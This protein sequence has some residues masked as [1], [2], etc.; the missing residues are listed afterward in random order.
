MSLGGLRTGDPKQVGEWTLVGRLGAGGMGVVYLAQGADGR[1]VALKRLREDLASDPEFRE[2]FRREAAALVR[3]QG[4]CTARVLTVDVEASSPYVVMEYVQGPTLAEY[5]GEQGPLRDGMAHGFAV[6]L[7]EALAAIHRAGVVHRDLKPGNVLLSEQGPK[8]IDFG[9]AQAADA[10]ALTRA[11]VAVG[12][13]GYM[14]P[15]QVRG[16]AGPPA[17]VF[18]W[19]LTVAYATTGRPPFGTGPAE[20]VLHRV[21]HEEPDLDGVPPHLRALLTSAL[22]G[23]PERRPTPGQL[24]SGLT[25]AQDPGT[26]LDVEAVTTVLATVWQMPEAAAPPAAVPRRR[27]AW[28]AAAGV[29]LLLSA[30]GILWNVLPGYGRPTASGP[31]SP[32]A[33]TAGGSSPASAPPTSPGTTAPGTTAPSTP[34]AT[35]PPPPSPSAVTGA[36]TNAHSGLCLDTNGPQRP[37][38]DVVLR[39]C[40]NFSGQIWR[41]DETGLHLTNTPS[42]LCLDTYGKPAAGVPAVLNPC[43]NYTGQQWR[44]DADSGRL[45]NPASGLCLDT[46]GPPA[47]DNV[48]LV[49]NPC[50]NR[51][52]QDWRM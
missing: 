7:A 46:N 13:V 20:A 31:A 52:G 19:A 2:R 18:A 3:V 49:L 47:S 9:I 29:V 51:T 24:L 6:G 28:F 30:A 27:T 32:P 40:G 48:A 12:T 37:G 44:Y 8:V 25:G 41:Y 16:Q 50:G 4:T 15:E 45:T 42:G 21:L 5:V 34:D 35:P 43:G 33:P 14:A 38:L 26:L 11:G 22:A 39:T 17:D 36:V 10:T 1:L 23:S